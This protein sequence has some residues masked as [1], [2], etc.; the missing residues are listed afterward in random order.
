MSR[1][2]AFE[3]GDACGKTL[4]TNYVCDRLRENGIDSVRVPIIEG[5]QVGCSDSQTRLILCE[6]FFDATWA[7]SA[8][9]NRSKINAC[10]VT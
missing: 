7:I 8:C 5:S 10:A 3:G 9:R 6:P 2:F 4:V 1:V